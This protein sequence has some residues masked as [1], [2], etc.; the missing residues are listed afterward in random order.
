MAAAKVTEAGNDVRP[1][2]KDPC[3][4]NEKTGEKT[5]VRKEGKVFVVDL[6]VKVPGSDLESGMSEQSR[7]ESARNGNG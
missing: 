3:I 4:I 1:N 5:T 2:R 6:W 7:K